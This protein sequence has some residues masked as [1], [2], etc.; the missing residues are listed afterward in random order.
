MCVPV[1]IPYYTGNT[2]KIHYVVSV[3]GIT[4]AIAR[5]RVLFVIPARL[6]KNTIQ[7]FN[8][9]IITPTILLPNKAIAIVSL[10]M[11]TESTKNQSKAKQDKEFF[12]GLSWFSP[13]KNPF[14]VLKE[15][16]MPKIFHPNFFL[17]HCVSSL[18]DY[19]PPLPD[20]HIIRRALHLDDPGTQ[21]NDV[22]YGPQPR[23]RPQPKAPVAPDQEEKETQEEAHVPRLGR[24]S[25][26]EGEVKRYRSNSVLWDGSSDFISTVRH[27]HPGFWVLIVLLVPVPLSAA[28]LIALWSSQVMALLRERMR[29]HSEEIVLPKGGLSYLGYGYVLMIGRDSP[30]HSREEHDK[31]P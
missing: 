26:P 12:P 18:I 4:V 10:K 2:G 14:P 15:L 17:F 19:V 22:P 9:H 1:E 25:K 21:E 16:T 30:H 8:D 5:V 7:A 6:D 20:G 13:R 29:P 23:P 3:S 31:S 11:T 28:A 27:I 24:I